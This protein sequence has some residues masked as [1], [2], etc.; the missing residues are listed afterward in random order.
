MRIRILK[1]TTGVMDRVS[2]SRLLPGLTYDVDASLA[3]HLIAQGAAQAASSPPALVVP[4]DVH[5]PHMEH[6]TGGITITD[7]PP[8]GA[9]DEGPS[10]RRKR[11]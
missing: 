3:G 11:R 10:R 8:R 6:L 9:H 7:P 5:D 4:I 1:A 2:L